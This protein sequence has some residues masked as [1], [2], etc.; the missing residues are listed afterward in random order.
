MP[1]GILTQAWSP[2]GGIRHYRGD[3]TTP[4]TDPTIRPSQTLYGKTT[5]QVMIRWHIQQ[6]RS[7]IPKSVRPDRIAE[8][9]NVFDFDLT[10]DE[11]ARIDA[12]NIGTHGP[13]SDRLRQLRP[14]HPRSLTGTRKGHCTTATRSEPGASKCSSSI[15]PTA[16]QGRDVLT[17]NPGNSS[18]APPQAS[19]PKIQKI[20]RRYRGHDPIFHRFSATDGGR[21]APFRR[22]R[23]GPA[24]SALPSSCVVAGETAGDGFDQRR[25]FAAHR[26]S[27]A[28]GYSVQL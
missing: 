28:P 13:R 7:A 8:N 20:R 21:A 4:L 26:G 25:G 12:L 17:V 14:H 24:H 27:R 1:H 15:S 2:I 16:R 5:A 9:F 19:C 6:G 10:A 11:L 3:T 23:S 18:S 22:P